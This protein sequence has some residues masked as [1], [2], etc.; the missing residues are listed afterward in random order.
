M[1]RQTQNQIWDFPTS[2]E[3]KAVYLTP[4]PCKVFSR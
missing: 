3:G 4:L 1:D 2:E